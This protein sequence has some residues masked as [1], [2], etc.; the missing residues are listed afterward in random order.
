MSSGRVAEHDDEDAV[1]G[2]RPSRL[3]ST[4]SPCKKVLALALLARPENWGVFGV[5]PEP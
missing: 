3:W 2:P 4:G 1:L 5:N